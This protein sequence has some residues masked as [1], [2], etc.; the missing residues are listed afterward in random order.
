MFDAFYRGDA[1]RTDAISHAGV[2]LSLTRRIV[3]LH[4]GDITIE[5]QTGGG[6]MVR[7]RLPIYGTA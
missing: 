4:G 6:T 5:N 2:G 3:M 1:A 7:V